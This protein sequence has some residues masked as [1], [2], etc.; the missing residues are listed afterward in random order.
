ML[1]KSKN[2]KRSLVKDASPKALLS[3]A[4][5]GF[6]FHFRENGVVLSK[7][8]AKKSYDTSRTEQTSH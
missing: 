6:S 4:W 1:L 2:G 5:N 7:W 8:N 3:L